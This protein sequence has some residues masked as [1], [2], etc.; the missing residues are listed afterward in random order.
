MRAA[1]LRLLPILLLL[2]IPCSLLAGQVV[3]HADDLPVDFGWQLVLSNSYENG[4]GITSSIVSDSGGNVWE[5]TDAS[6]L[7]RCAEANTTLTGISFDTGVTLAA[8]VKCT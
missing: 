3:Y 1:G 4:G 8:R 5:L 7:T 2:L 6:G